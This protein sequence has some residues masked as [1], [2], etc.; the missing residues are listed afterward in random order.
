MLADRP[1][2]NQKDFEYWKTTPKRNRP[3]LEF[4]KPSFKD[5]NWSGTEIAGW[6]YLNDFNSNKILFRR[7]NIFR[8]TVLASWYDNYFGYNEKIRISRYSSV[9][10]LFREMVMQFE[11][12]RKGKTSETSNIVELVNIA[13]KETF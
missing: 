11:K 2:Y 3:I 8:Y 12:V 10:T 1:G 6:V 7:G 13:N 5:Q 4:I 9:L